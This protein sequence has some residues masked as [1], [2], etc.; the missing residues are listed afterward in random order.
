ML[1]ERGCR[2]HDRPAMGARDPERYA[3]PPDWR[4]HRT[5]GQMKDAGWRLA[6]WCRRCGHSAP[7][8]I[9]LLIEMRGTEAS[10]WDRFMDCGRSGCRGKAVF[11]AATGPGDVWYRLT[12]NWAQTR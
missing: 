4:R 12:R 5:L 11:K 8:D 10:P 1:D 7:L 3:L 9:D 2:P 6:T